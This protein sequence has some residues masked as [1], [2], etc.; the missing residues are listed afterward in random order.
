[1]AISQ[2]MLG[3]ATVFNL[4][5]SVSPADCPPTMIPIAEVRNISA[6]KQKTDTVDVTH[7]QSPGRRREFIAGLIDPGDTSFE[8]NF[9]PGT[10]SMQLIETWLSTG[11]VAD[12][13]II[14]PNLV[15][16]TFQGIVVGY[17]VKAE[18]AAA[19]TATVT[20]KVTGT[21]SIA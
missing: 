12:C 15:A 2:A 3:Y 9:V 17:D 13:N 4:E 10:A 8:C 18:T 16:W 11:N 5:S 14:F 6:P 7:N 20:M 21:I 19:L 1:M